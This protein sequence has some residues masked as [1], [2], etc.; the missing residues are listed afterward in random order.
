MVFLSK[1]SFILFFFFALALLKVDSLN[2]LLLSED[3]G[4]IELNF[5]LTIFIFGSS[6]IFNSW[7]S[8]VINL[9]KV[10]C[11]ENFASNSST[12]IFSFGG[13]SFLFIIIEFLSLSSLS[14]V[15][16]I[17]EFLVFKS[18][19]LF[20]NFIMELARLNIFVFKI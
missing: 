10:F 6:L 15:F 7:L 16:I 14:L 20:S 19:S 1:E 18:D 5:L 17:F 11:E 9:F 13:D 12:F 8:W 3:L 2:K 4:N